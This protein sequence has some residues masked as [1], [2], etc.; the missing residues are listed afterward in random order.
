MSSFTK[1]RDPSQQSLIKVLVLLLILLLILTVSALCIGA[2]DITPLEVVKILGTAITGSESNAPDM[3]RIIVLTVRLPRVIS[4]ILVGAALAVAGCAYQGI[5][6]N[7]LVS[8]DLLGVS[9][10]ACIGAAVAI[11][12]GWGTTGIQGAAF[13]GGLAAVALTMSI[14][15]LIRKQSTLALVL[16]GIIVGGFCGSILGILKYVADPEEDLPSIVYWQMGSLAKSDFEKLAYVTPVILISIVIL[17]LLRWRMNVL[18]LGD[19]EAMALG[20]NLKRERAAVIVFATLLTASAVSLAGTIGWVG[21]V[22]PHLAR[23]I[24]GQ[25]IARTMPVSALLAASFMIVVDT[26]ARS[27]GIEIPLGILTG[28]VGTPFFIL[29][30]K[31][32]RSTLQ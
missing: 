18:S 9:S 28:L 19:K 14:P 6:R 12:I 8:P 10:G 23:F 31:K 22:V 4:A 24:V 27:T 17:L 29:L 5:F 21:L 3:T 7:P 25:N 15:R 20:V 16:S 30:L 11:L 32:Q 2:Y 1:K 13:V 26:I